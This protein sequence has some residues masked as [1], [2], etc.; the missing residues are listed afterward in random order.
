MCAQDVTLDV[1][2]ESYPGR[3]NVPETSTEKG[4]LM[5]PGAGH[6]P[7]GDIF[8]R[9]ART[10]A[11]DGYEVARFETW[12]FVSDLEEKT[13]DDFAAE[14]EAGVEFLQS[15][16]CSTITM[17][18]KS[19]GGQKALKHRP[20]AVDRLVLWAPYVTTGEDDE[21]PSITVD[22]LA[23]IEIPVRILQGDEDRGLSV[24]NAETLAEHLPQG[25]VVELPGEDHSFRNE[26]ARIIDET[27]D[28]L[29]D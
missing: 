7:F 26:P 10:A 8:L 3:L 23:E 17:I 11:G 14:L 5:V 19:F 21:M 15:R 6:G 27:M 13:A 2:G 9:F 16:D 29:P 25:E 24:E 28:Y 12:P 1:G 20:D 22:D 4:V 18:A